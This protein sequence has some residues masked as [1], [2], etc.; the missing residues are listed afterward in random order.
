MSWY[1]KTERVE[2]L[3]D[4]RSELSGLIN[5]G[6]SYAPFDALGVCQAIYLTS[7]LLLV[8]PSYITSLDN[9]EGLSFLQ[10]MDALLLGSFLVCGTCALLTSAREFNI[11][12]LRRQVSSIEVAVTQ[13]D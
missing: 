7:R 5:L 1:P 2:S 6:N 4:A 12:R 9:S 13:T 11:Y 10:G 3:E 8:D